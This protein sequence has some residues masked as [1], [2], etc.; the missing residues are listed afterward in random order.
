MSDPMFFSTNPGRFARG[1]GIVVTQ[2]EATWDGAN[3]C[4]K[5]TNTRDFND[6]T[7]DI[8]LF[9]KN[10]GLVT[11]SVFNSSTGAELKRNTEHSS[12]SN[13]RS[14]DDNHRIPLSNIAKF[15][16]MNT[17]NQMVG[18]LLI[19]ATVAHQ[20][21]LYKSDTVNPEIVFPRSG[22]EI[23]Y[24][25]KAFSETGPLMVHGIQILVIPN[26]TV[27]V[28]LTITKRPANVTMFGKA[29]ESGRGE[30]TARWRIRRKLNDTNLQWEVE[31][32]P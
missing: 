3:F 9:L 25:T 19:G 28:V 16:G 23:K 18:K 13:R 29:A 14:P 7:Y 4:L 15:H 26:S 10:K 22:F 6:P 31:P 24:S 32:L 5:V 30:A 1:P 21:F 2:K 20:L 8:G 12:W 27:Y 17:Q 11:E